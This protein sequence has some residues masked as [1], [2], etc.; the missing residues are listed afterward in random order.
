MFIQING[1]ESVDAE[2]FVVMMQELFIHP[3]CWMIL[4]HRAQ[5]CNLTV[6]WTQ[7]KVIQ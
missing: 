3:H 1:Y 2:L 7:S 4:L 5:Y 6:A